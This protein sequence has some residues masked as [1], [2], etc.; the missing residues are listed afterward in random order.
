MKRPRFHLD[1]ICIIVLLAALNLAWYRE[2]LRHGLNY[3]SAFGFSDRGFDG[4]VLPMLTILV[5]GLY[6]LFRRGRSAF[7]LGFVM[8]GLVVTL[9]FMLWIW[10]A[11]LSV[12]DILTIR[13]F[14]GLVQALRG[15]RISVQ[16]FLVTCGIIDTSLQLSVAL[17]GGWLAH[18]MAA[19]RG[20]PDSAPSR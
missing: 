9:A 20:T 10:V 13:P 8:T 6:V 14:P 2:Y 5:I 18:W 16:T 17:L 3:P 11:P 19:R 12:T 4:S 15:N 1:T 7:L